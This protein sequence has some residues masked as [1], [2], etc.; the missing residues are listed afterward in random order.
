[1]P[2]GAWDSRP[3]RRTRRARARSSRGS[4]CSR[5][6][7]SRLATAAASPPPNQNAERSASA[8]HRAARGRTRTPGHL[9]R[10]ACG[11]NASKQ[12]VPAVVT[13][14][15]S[16]RLL[17]H[18]N[19]H[20]RVRSPSGA[21]DHKRRNFWVPRSRAAD[22]TCFMRGRALKLLA[23]GVTSLAL[24]AALLAAEPGPVPV[25]APERVQGGRRAHLPAT[26]GSSRSAGQR[27]RAAPASQQGRCS[28]GVRVRRDAQPTYGR[29]GPSAD[30]STV[31]E[32][33]K[34]A[35][36]RSALDWIMLAAEA[37][38]QDAIGS[39]CRVAQDPLAPAHFQEKG[40]ARCEELRRKYP[41]K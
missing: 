24:G 28:G 26:A 19:H 40:K 3:R 8:R 13:C 38:N 22:R 23:A 7:A 17:W 39:V 4:S 1:M 37:G 21:P 34:L 29:F 16:Q 10:V 6:S 31:A 30:A 35:N 25:P 33:S 18:A 20:G 41:A 27:P 9:G 12:A 15:H 2:G 11:P 36:D 32:W 14:K 5:I